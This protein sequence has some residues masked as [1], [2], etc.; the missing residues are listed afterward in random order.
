[1]NA[2]FAYQLD[3]DDLHLTLTRHLRASFPRCCPGLVDETVAEI[4]AQ[5][6]ASIQRQ[7]GA[8]WDRLQLGS[9]AGLQNMMRVAAWRHLRGTLRG[10]AHSRT[11]ALEDGIIRAPQEHD[12]Q[13]V[14]MACELLSLIRSL[15]E[16]AAR[17]HSKRHP[18][19]LESA[20]RERLE[21][22]ESDT[23][24]AAKHGVDRGTLCNA[25]N[26]VRRRLDELGVA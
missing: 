21:T 13:A 24:I 1:M 3:F 15:V 18:H 2:S 10:F 16:E 9:E 20:L 6:L 5:T 19:R 11:T 23:A 26:W 7:E 25:R 8:F 4:L 17:R 12:P 14:A 22:G